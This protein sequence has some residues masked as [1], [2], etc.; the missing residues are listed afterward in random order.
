M[1]LFKKVLLLST[2]A[3]VIFGMSAVAASAQTKLVVAVDGAP[4]TIEES[5]GT[6]FIDSAS[7]TQV[8]IR[9]ISEKLGAKIAWDGTTQT[10]TINGSIKIKVGSTEISTAYGTVKM[11]TQAVNKDGRIYVPFRYVANALGYD[12]E[13]K[14]ENGTITANVITKADLTVS[15][16]ASLKDALNEVQTLYK[17]EKPNT[18]IAINYGGSGTLQQQIEQGAPVDLFFSAATSNMT[19]LKDKGLLNDS[20]IKNLL[21]NKLV[22]VVPKDSKA[23]ITSFAEVASSSAI[24]KLA[25]GEPTTVPAGKYALQ[26]F[27]YYNATET[28]TGKAI[29]AKDVREVLTWVESGNADAGA[30][31]STDAKT[32]DKVKVVATATDGSHDPILY[33]AAVIKSTKH[34]VATEDFLNFLTTD[35]AKAIFV[36]YG[37]SVL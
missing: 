2:I 28:V 33:P 18:T 17:T 6:P 5:L 8:P 32:S 1:K 10:A 34:A 16:A 37:F 4:M 20:T 15:A 31:Y 29:Y 14:S 7:R 12:I 35:A 11:D 26:V 36:K 27:K 3:A 19:A 13:A 9:A 23:T 30:V 21:Q 22:L 25:L 24:K